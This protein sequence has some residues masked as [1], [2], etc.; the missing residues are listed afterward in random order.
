MHPNV[1]LLLQQV[2]YDSHANCRWTHRFWWYLFQGFFSLFTVALNTLWLQSNHY[3]FSFWVYQNYSWLSWISHKWTVKNYAAGFSLQ[4]GRY[5][6]RPSDTVKAVRWSLT[7]LFST[8]T[9]ISEKNSVKAL[10]VIKQSTNLT[11]TLTISNMT[12][13]E[14]SLQLGYTEYASVFQ[15]QTLSQPLWSAA[16]I[17]YIHQGHGH[18]QLPYSLLLQLLTLNIHNMTFTYWTFQ[19]WI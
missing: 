7:S 4:D 17:I 12:R 18:V 6:C 3:N 16:C 11:F 19:G 10:K 5:C 13:S 1:M 9:A 15:W 14:R 2:C 8:N